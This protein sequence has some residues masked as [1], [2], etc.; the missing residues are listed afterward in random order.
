MLSYQEYELI[1]Q[2]IDDHIAGMEGMLKADIN[3]VMAS[4]LFLNPDLPAEESE[5][6]IQERLTHAKED[7]ESLKIIK[8]KLLN[9]IG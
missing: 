3:D 6:Y 1:S 4:V 5:I 2:A 9:F 8:Q 7:I